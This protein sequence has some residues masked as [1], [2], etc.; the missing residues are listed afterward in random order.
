MIPFLSACFTE[1]R[2]KGVCAR[3]TRQKGEQT[4]ERE[5]KNLT[6]I[7]REEKLDHKNLALWKNHG[8]PTRLTNLDPTCWLS[9]TAQ[10]NISPIIKGGAAVREGRLQDCG[11]EKSSS[12]TREPGSK[13]AVV[14]MGPKHAR[15]SSLRKED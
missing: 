11:P 10:P 6:C 9:S 13:P 1:L 15:R 8:R 7:Q 12:R 5:R 2:A 14:P 4:R 3:K